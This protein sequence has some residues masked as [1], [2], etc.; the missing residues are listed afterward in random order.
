MRGTARV[1]PLDPARL[2]RFLARYLGEDPD[3]WDPWFRERVVDGLDLAVRFVPTSV[4][5]RDLSYSAPRA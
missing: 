2:Y 4:L 1:V 5:A 3:S